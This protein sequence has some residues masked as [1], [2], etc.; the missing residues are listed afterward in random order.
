MDMYHLNITPPNLHSS[1]LDF[2]HSILK[3]VGYTNAY[4][5]GYVSYLAVFDTWNVFHPPTKKKRRKDYG[6]GS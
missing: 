3:N 4:F 1:V 2:T 6:R 5:F